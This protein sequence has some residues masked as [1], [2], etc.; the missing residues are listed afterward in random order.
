MMRTRCTL[1]LFLFS[2]LAMPATAGDTVA[3]IKR[4]NAENFKDRALGA[5]ISAA[6][7]GSP[8]GK[9]ANVTTSAFLE[10]TYYDFDEANPAVDR[11]AEK[12]LRR[13]YANP[14]EGYAGAE[15][16]LLKCLDMFHSKELN[17]LVK[18]YVPHPSWI[19]DKPAK[20][21]LAGR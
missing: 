16:K 14:V 10:W 7:D 20:K 11:L 19:G 13:N 2:A 18:K 1:V 15:F 4:T 6:Y 17:E 3:A 21:K 8:A 5:C 9:D 12:Y